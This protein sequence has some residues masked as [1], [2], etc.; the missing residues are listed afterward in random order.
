M[1]EGFS[2]QPCQMNE[3]LMQRTRRLLEMR[4][5]LQLELLSN[6]SDIGPDAV[7]EALARL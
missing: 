3:P 5:A 6:H 7:A 4:M 2:Q 1:V